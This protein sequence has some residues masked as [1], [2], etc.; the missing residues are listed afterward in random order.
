MTDKALDEGRLQPVDKGALKPCPLCG[1]EAFMQDEHW[2]D[3]SLR[4]REPICRRCG[5]KMPR[6]W[7]GRKEAGAIAAW[8]ARQPETGAALTRDGREALECGL[9]D[10]DIAKLRELLDHTE[11]HLPKIPW[12]VIPSDGKPIIAGRKGSGNLFRGYIATWKEADLA[13][14]AVNSMSALLDEIQ[15][16]RSVVSDALKYRTAGGMRNALAPALHAAVKSAQSRH[17]ALAQPV[18]AGEDGT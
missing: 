10:D 13:C 7:R 18:E 16:L 15:M 5:L 9:S 8:N 4:G 11:R 17:A 1:G 3:G 6:H 2:Y 14:L 12:R